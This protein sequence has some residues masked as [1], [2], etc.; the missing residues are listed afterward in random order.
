MKESPYKGK[1][2]FSR[3]VNALGY[4]LDGLGAGWRNEAAFR[5]VSLLAVAGIVTAFV[6]PLPAWARAVVIGSHVLTVIV[7][8]LNSAIEA[9]VDHTSLE[10]HH[11]AKRAKDL[12]SAA[13]LVCLGNLALMWGLALF[14]R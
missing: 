2:G 3:V 5:Q 13:Q 8:L 12:G 10:K 14:G 9:A 6:L 11:L 1:R 7:E 4:S